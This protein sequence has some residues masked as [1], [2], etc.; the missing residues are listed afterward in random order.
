[1]HAF[2]GWI[3]SCCYH[4]QSWSAIVFCFHVL[5]APRKLLQRGIKLSL[6]AKIELAFS[7][8]T[9]RSSTIPTAKDRH[10]LNELRNFFE[11]STRPDAEVLLTLVLV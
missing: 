4:E 9:S 7:R 2:D 6:L 8:E 5:V 1:M 10:D 3:M 11:S